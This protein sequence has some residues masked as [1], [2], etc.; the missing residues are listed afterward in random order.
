MLHVLI[1]CPNINHGRPKLSL[2]TTPKTKQSSLVSSLDILNAREKFLD[3][4]SYNVL[5]NHP[6]KYIAESFIIY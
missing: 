6:G 5:M 2:V 1:Y 3:I 4:S